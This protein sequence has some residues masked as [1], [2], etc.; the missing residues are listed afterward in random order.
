[1]VADSEVVDS[2]VVVDLEE[3]GVIEG[4][5]EDVVL[6]ATT[7]TTTGCDWAW[8]KVLLSKETG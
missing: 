7:L 8:I 1:M 6:G 3:V 2:E 4:S 5:F